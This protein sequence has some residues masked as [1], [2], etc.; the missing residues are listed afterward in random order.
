MNHARANRFLVATLVCLCGSGFAQIDTQKD[1]AICQSFC[2]LSNTQ[3]DRDLLGAGASTLVVADTLDQL[4]RNARTNTPGQM[5]QLPSLGK[6]D[7]NT[8][9]FRTA[10]R[11]EVERLQCVKAC[12][13]TESKPETPQ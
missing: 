9:G 1:V 12:A 6:T 13:A 4:T 3:C 5:A 7:D 2:T 11:C 8:P 10:K